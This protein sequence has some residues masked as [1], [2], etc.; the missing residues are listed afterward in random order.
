[1]Q[2]LPKDVT[3]EEIGQLV[4]SLDERDTAELV[5]VWLDADTKEKLKK[6]LK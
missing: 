6:H 4:K 1:M 2:R 5:D 3:I